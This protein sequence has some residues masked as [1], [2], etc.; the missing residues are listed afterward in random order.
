MKEIFEIFVFYC[1]S[2]IPD[3]VFY[4]IISLSLLSS[5]ILYLHR[6]HLKNRHI[7]IYPQILAYTIIILCSTIICRPNNGIHDYS[8]YLF[9]SYVE[10]IKGNNDFIAEIGLNI[11]LFIP[12]GLL[13]GY[14]FDKC[15]WYNIILLGL[16]LSVIIE[17]SQLAFER[18]LCEIDD[19]IHNTIGCSFGYLL[20]KFTA[21]LFIRKD[22]I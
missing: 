20:Y 14:A 18:G 17:I 3:P 11:I 21:K 10:L 7:I 22:V 2:G 1:H 19:V 6:V 15:K 9:W 5:L 4:A 16:L 12:F 8:F 13:T